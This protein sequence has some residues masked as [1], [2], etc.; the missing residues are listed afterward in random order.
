M[1][2][3]FLFGQRAFPPNTP[4]TRLSEISEIQSNRSR[5][6]LSTLSSAGRLWAGIESPYSVLERSSRSVRAMSNLRRQR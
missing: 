1:R 6:K 2:A 5:A 4:R 3:S